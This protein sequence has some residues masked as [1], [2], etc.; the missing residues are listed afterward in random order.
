MISDLQIKADDFTLSDFFDLTKEPERGLFPEVTNDLAEF[1]NRSG[2]RVT[3]SNYGTR[4]INLEIYVYNKNV[5]QLKDM[6]AEILVLKQIRLWFSDEPDRYFNAYLD[7]ESA[8]NRSETNAGEFTGTLKFIVPEGV[9]HSIDSK[10][11][12]IIDNEVTVENK[13]TNKAPLDIHTTFTSDAD[14]IGFVS[15]DHTVQLGTAYSE[16]EENF[17]PSNKIINDTM[18]TKQKQHWRENVGRVRWRSDSGDN[19]SQI[20]GSIDWNDKESAANVK[21]WGTI[22]ETK[23]GFWHGPTI[24]RFLTNELPNF[25]AFHRFNFK[26]INGKYGKKGA[27]G[28]LE[29]N[30]ADADSNFVMGFEMKDNTDKGEKIKYSFFIGTTRIIEMNLP[31]KIAT[32]G[33]GFFGSIQMTKIGN[34]FTFKLA[35]LRGTPLKETWSVTKTYHNETVAM[36]NASRID[37]Y[38]SQWKNFTAMKLGLTHTRLTQINTEDNTMV[39]LTFYEGDELFVE[40]TTNRVYINGIRDDNYRVIGSSQFLEAPKGKSEYSVLTDGSYEGYL[41]MRERYL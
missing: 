27:Q 26:P 18:G 12:P 4:D 31:N 33:G 6:L 41:E 15:E 8:L 38:M 1:G 25:E 14:S 2:T 32:E 3:Q 36:L 40:G 24:T 39:P 7:G 10:R 19:T 5:R 20:M 30:Y 17:V 21:S 11:F 29:I 16:D 35:R 28:L 23:A 9:S 22:D 37:C 34:E 13:G